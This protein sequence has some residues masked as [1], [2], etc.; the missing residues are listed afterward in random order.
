MI[1]W[2]K[3]RSKEESSHHGAGILLAC[4]LIVA[5]GGLAKILAYVG[6]AYSIW[7]ICKKG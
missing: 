4:L 1:D 7:R 6:I 2:I 5:F 3:S